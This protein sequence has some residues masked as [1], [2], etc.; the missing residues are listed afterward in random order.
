MTDSVR[1]DS[2][3]RRGLITPLIYLQTTCYANQ[4]RIDQDLVVS[5]LNYDP[6]WLAVRPWFTRSSSTG[7]W[8]TPTPGDWEYVGPFHSFY[9]SAHLNSYNATPNNYYLVL[10]QV[11]EWDPFESRWI[12]WS[13]SEWANQ[14]AIRIA[15]YANVPDIPYCNV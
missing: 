5:D 14:Y 12:N 10:T 11:Y 9:G 2:D 7:A 15:G 3:S 1:A 8:E 4:G 6:G 13:A